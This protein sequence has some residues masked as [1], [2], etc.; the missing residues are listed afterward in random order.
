MKTIVKHVQ[1]L[2]VATPA[3]MLFTASPTANAEIYKWRDHFGRTQYADKPPVAG[4]TKATRNEIVNALQK[5][6][7][8]ALTLDNSVSMLAVSKQTSTGDNV[9]KNNIAQIADTN[10]YSANFFANFK[11]RLVTQTVANQNWATAVNKTVTK[12][13]VALPVKTINN[14]FS[15]LKPS[16]VINTGGLN[17]NVFGSP[18]KPIA[19]APRPTVPANAAPSPV[20]LPKTEAPIVNK[21]A[22]AALPTTPIPVAATPTPVAI[23]PTE[24]VK[25]ATASPTNAPNNTPNNTPNIIQ[26][27]LM[28]AVD[29]SKNMLQN[30]GFANLRIQAT[31]E[32]SP[33]TSGGA[34]RISCTP[35]HMSNDDPIVYPNQ[36]GAA[37][38]HTFYGNTTTDF[39]SNL[40]TFANVGNSTCTGGTMNKSAYWVPSMIDTA[41]KTPILPE[42]TIFYY[43]VGRFE[44]KPNLIIAPPKGLRMIAGNAKGVSATTSSANYTCINNKGESIPWVKSIPN[45]AVGQTME[46]QVAFPQCWDG[47]NLD[48]P[49][50]KSHM[51]FPIDETCPSTHPKVL[52]ELRV[53]FNFKVNTANAT[54]TWRLASDNYDNNL[55]AG[56]SSHADWVNG[57]DVTIMAGIVKNCL[58]SNRDGHAHLLCDGRMF[59]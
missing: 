43:K 45:C 57:W 4:F 29:I 48:S 59:F 36:Q 22:P 39:K 56:F 37:H 23:K 28:P 25:L 52:P 49:D 58:N 24:P 40:M 35:S 1:L 41:T 34:F 14:S 20:A 11:K 51:A 33:V 2:L 15:P 26:K 18:A 3:I 7:L 10:Q 9:A 42:G 44:K 53:N 38:H 21:P 47:V 16:A 54:K 6:E 13:S 17:V 27:D 12:P 32:I 19:T 46:M 31:T 55:P 50:H 8:C 5:K 30:T